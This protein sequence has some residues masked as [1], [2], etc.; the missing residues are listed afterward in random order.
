M[1]NCT[2]RIACTCLAM[3]DNRAYRAEDRIIQFLIGLNEEYHGVVSQVLLMDPLPQ[4]NKVFSMVMQQER[5]ICGG[6]S[7]GNSSVD[8]N[9]GMV[10]AAESNKQI[11]NGRG[12]GTFNGGGQR[13]GHG[14]GRGRGN[15]KVC[16]YYG[17][18]G[19]IIDCC[20]KKHGYPQVLEEEVEI[21]PMQIK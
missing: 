14:S 12:R 13:G 20:Y 11:G 8:D 16:T 9:S 10:N 5:K 15:V 21:I 7:I 6:V 18:T 19:H 4:I 2:C 17:K 3:R 1:P